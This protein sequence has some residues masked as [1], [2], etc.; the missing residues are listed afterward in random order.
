VDSEPEIHT[1]AGGVRGGWENVVAVFRRYPYAAPPVGSR[2]AGV[3]SAGSQAD[4]AGSVMSSAST[5]SAGAGQPTSP[6]RHPTWVSPSH[7][8]APTL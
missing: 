3:R 8:S 2:R 7:N 6:G 1:A 4:L 5:P